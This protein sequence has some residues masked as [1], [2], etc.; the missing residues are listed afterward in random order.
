MFLA[1]ADVKSALETFCRVQYE[2]Y[3]AKCNEAMV[4]EKQNIQVA[5]QGAHFALCY[6]SLMAELVN[7]A[8]NQLRNQ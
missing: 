3:S 7:F 6:S 2:F 4:G 8:E 1:D 5:R